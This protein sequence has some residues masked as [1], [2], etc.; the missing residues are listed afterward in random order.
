MIYFCFSSEEERQAGRA[1]GKEGRLCVCVC[2][3]GGGGGGE[4][5]LYTGGT[6]AA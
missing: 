6:T 2:G 1:G 3:G 5:N 4:E